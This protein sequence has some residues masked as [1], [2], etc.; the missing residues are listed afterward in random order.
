MI[1][2]LPT[3]AHLPYGGVAADT[4]TN[5]STLSYFRSL[6]H[7]HRRPFVY[8]VERIYYVKKFSMLKNLFNVN[9]TYALLRILRLYYFHIESVVRF[10]FNKYTKTFPNFLI[11]LKL[12]F[13]KFEYRVSFIAYKFLIYYVKII[14]FFNNSK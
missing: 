7:D 9:Q 1:S 14:L 13:Y 5:A 6:F 10:C 3:Q 11:F 4:L 12:F 2:H 8:Y